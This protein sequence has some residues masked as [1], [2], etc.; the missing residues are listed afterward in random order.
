MPLVFYYGHATPTENP[1]LYRHLVS[2]LA[3]LLNRREALNSQV[4]PKR[5]LQ[6][7]GQARA[8]RP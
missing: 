6:L 5:L 2:Q 1:E 8:L 3:Q 7:T 4:H